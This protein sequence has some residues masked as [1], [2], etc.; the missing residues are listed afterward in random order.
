MG[1]FKG[2]EYQ[3]LYNIWCI[4]FAET[5]SEILP[6]ARFL[7]QSSETNRKLRQQTHLGAND[8]PASSLAS[9]HN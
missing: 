4:I 5:H 6:S 9:W 8:P 3:R 1:D 7:V 2:S